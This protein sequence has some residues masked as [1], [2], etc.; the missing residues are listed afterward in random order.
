MARVKAVRMEIKVPPAAA[1]PI[2]TLTEEVP[3]L[4]QSV[5]L[6]SEGDCSVNSSTSTNLPGSWSFS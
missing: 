4:D 2:K 1:L 5:N 3:M 6:A